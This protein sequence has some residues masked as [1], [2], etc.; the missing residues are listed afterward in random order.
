[1]KF[2]IE[3]A[4]DVMLYL[5]LH[6]KPHTT[7]SGKFEY[8]KISMKKLVDALTPSDHYTPDEVKYAIIQL[9]Q[10]NMVKARGAST[11]QRVSILDV[12]DITPDGHTF[13]ESVRSPKFFDKLKTHLSGTA[14]EAL[15][16]APKFALK[17]LL[18][19]HNEL[20][21]AIADSIPKLLG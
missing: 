13:I 21:D 3:A 4:R 2:K 6:L 19:D 1:M 5:E 9:H 20:P 17:I 14:E 7:A 10:S 15:K 18:A 12:Y 8:D 16:N 11:D